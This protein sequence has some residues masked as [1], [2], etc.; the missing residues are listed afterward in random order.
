MPRVRFVGTNNM[1]KN[2]V[3]TRQRI[4]AGGG[5]AGGHICLLATTNP[6]LNDANDDR[7]T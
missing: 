6:G 4:I 5:S 2:W 1:L 7:N 3:S